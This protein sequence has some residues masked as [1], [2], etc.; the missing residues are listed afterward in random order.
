[1]IRKLQ[2]LLLAAVLA[3]LLLVLAWYDPRYALL[4][5]LGL[6]LCWGYTL[7]FIAR[8]RRRG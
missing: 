7:I 3:F 6:F 4:M 5:V 8:P 1:M 2:H